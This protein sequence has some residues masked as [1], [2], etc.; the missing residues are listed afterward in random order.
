MAGATMQ[1]DSVRRALPWEEIGVRG[2]PVRDGGTM[3][4]AVQF[5]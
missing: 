3:I 4:S 2:F 1:R 5:D